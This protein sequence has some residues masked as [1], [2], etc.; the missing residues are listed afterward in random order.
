M[1]VSY[2]HLDVYKRQSVSFVSG[3]FSLSISGMSLAAIVGILLNLLLPNETNTQDTTDNTNIAETIDTTPAE[4]ETKKFQSVIELNHPLIEHKL[5]ILRDKNT[6]TKEFRELAG[7]IG[8]FLC[9]KAMEDIQLEKTEIETPLCKLK[10]GKLN[11]DNYAFVPILR[12]CLLYTSR[13]V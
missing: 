1:P 11:E 4:K 8:M 12:A 10:T 7:E 5:G 6:G 9:Y 2:T 3:D 13:C